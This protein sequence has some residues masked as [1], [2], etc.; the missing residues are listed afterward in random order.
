LT[1]ALMC[2]DPHSSYMSPST[3]EDF[4]ISMALSLDGI[5]AALRSE[6]GYTIVAEI[7][8]GGAAD[9]DGR[10]KVGDKIIGVGQEEGEIEDI[11]DLKLS[12]VVR[13]IRG[14]RGSK[15]RLQVKPE[16]GEAQVYEMVRQKIELTESEV[17]G[18]IIES[19]DRVDRSGRIGVIKIPRS[20]EHTSELQ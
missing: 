10:L 20:E 2:L 18:E 7:V 4:N 3:L 17:K 9:K 11:V 14:E 13:K 1:T 6:D 16:T 5:G 19:K 12:K 15:V 8:P